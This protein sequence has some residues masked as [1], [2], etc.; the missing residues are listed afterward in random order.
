MKAK[1]RILLVLLISI[2]IFVVE[3]VLV[4][5]GLT[6]GHS[7]KQVDNTELHAGY[8]SA[9][10]VDCECF[11]AL[12]SLVGIILCLRAFH[13]K[14]YCLPEWFDVLYMMGT[15]SLTLV[16]LVVAVYLA[17]IKAANG[18][19]YF[20]LFSG[21]NFFNHFLNPWLAIVCFDVIN[22]TRKLSWKRAWFAPIPMIV[23]AG[24]YM[25]NVAVL[26]VWPDLYSFSFG[27]HYWVFPIELV[28]IFGVTFG[29]GLLHLK[30]HG[31][32]K[33]TRRH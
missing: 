6:S 17:P 33:V 7:I 10:T 2:F 16:F 20:H 8:F 12:V 4:T 24:I 30:M 22:K 26:K 29:L 9:F 19:G 32:E 11:M 15:A 18:Y 28:L 25:F 1:N 13:R 27:G 21:G 3:A 5:K 23:Y 31:I 14:E